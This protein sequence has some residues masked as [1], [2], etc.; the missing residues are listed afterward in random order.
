MF[1]ASPR[2]PY[3]HLL[4]VTGAIEV[5]GNWAAYIVQRMR[6]RHPLR[7]ASVLGI[8]EKAP[9]VPSRGL[10]GCWLTSGSRG[11]VAALAGLCACLR[12][13]NAFLGILPGC[14]LAQP[15]GRSS[16]DTDDGAVT[17]CSGGFRL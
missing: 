14:P 4:S 10:G 16:G 8:T 7:V 13:I 17:G 5:L 12:R 3:C 2:C 1:R 15:D 9:G 11:G 6:L